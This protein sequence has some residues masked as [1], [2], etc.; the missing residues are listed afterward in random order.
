MGLEIIGYCM[1]RPRIHEQP[2][3]H[4]LPGPLRRGVNAEAVTCELSRRLGVLRV[5]ISINTSAQIPVIQPSF[6]V[7]TDH[8]IPNARISVQQASI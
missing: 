2:G 7:R 6:T 1:L 3:G 4:E 5:P 8:D